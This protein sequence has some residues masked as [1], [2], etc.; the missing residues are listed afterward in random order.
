MLGASVTCEVVLYCCS[1]YGPLPAPA[2][3][4]EFSHCSALSAVEAF[5]PSVPPCAFT[6]FEFRMPVGGF[7]RIPGSCPSGV[8]ELIIPV[9]FPRHSGEF[10]DLPRSS[11]R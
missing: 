9:T 2:D 5:E 10:E 11:G 7:A 4:D 6:S 1:V 8:R 3:A